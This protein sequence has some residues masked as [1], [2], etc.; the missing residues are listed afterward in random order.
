MRAVVQRV[1]YSE[2]IVDNEIA[3]VGDAMIGKFPGSIF[4]P[5]ADN[6]PVLV[7]SWGKLLRTGSLLFLPSHGT[8]NNRRLVEKCYMNRI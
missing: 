4:P 6:V 5:F 3:L 1:E 8:Q 7:S 2:V